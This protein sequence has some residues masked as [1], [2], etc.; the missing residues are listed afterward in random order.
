MQHQVDFSGHKN[1]IGHVMAD[2]IEVRIAG[3]MHQVFPAAGDEI[4]HTDHI[5]TS[6]NET[7]A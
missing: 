4:V 7:V 2:E 1:E 3:Q 5:V 6:V